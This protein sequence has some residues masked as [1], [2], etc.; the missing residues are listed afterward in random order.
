MLDS[1][2]GAQGARTSILPRAACG[3]VNLGQLRGVCGHAELALLLDMC[4]LIKEQQHNPNA[5]APES[6]FELDRTIA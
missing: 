3:C 1:V 4:L 6:S 5:P 2:H